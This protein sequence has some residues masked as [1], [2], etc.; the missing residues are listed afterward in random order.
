MLAYIVLPKHRRALDLKCKIYFANIGVHPP[1]NFTMILQY[2]LI[3]HWYMGQHIVF[4]LGSPLSKCIV[5]NGYANDGACIGE[6]WYRSISSN[7]N[8][9]AFHL[10]STS[11]GRFQQLHRQSCKS[12]RVVLQTMPGPWL[13]WRGH[14]G[15]TL[16]LVPTPH[17]WFCQ[18]KRTTAPPVFPPRRRW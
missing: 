8:A 16:S 17:S 5:I 2:H 7:C 11:H 14:K 3:I 18:D 1:K 10:N 9:C 15:C 12:T 6:Y 13:S 4:V